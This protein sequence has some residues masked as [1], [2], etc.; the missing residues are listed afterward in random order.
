MVR[1]LG[2]DKKPHS[3]LALPGIARSFFGRST[4]AP[5]CMEVS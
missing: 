4:S 3:R 2:F 1:L 5:Q